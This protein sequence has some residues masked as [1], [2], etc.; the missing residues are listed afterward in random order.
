M[1][2]HNE[3]SLLGHG[4]PLV[5]QHCIFFLDPNFP[6]T[7]PGTANAN[8]RRPANF[9]TGRYFSYELPVTVHFIQKNVHTGYKSTGKNLGPQVNIC[10][11]QVPAI[12]RV[13]NN[14]FHC[15]CYELIRNFWTVLKLSGLFKAVSV[16]LWISKRSSPL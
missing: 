16:C 6:C 9:C 13:Q 8:W 14:R 4:C 11:M 12:S 5:C 10:Y 7:K 1:V 15:I 3:P 2:C